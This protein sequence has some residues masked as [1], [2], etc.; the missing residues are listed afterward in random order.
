MT[1]QAAAVALPDAP[2][3]C[4]ELEGDPHNS[5]PGFELGNFTFGALPAGET[6]TVEVRRDHGEDDKDEPG[7]L[8]VYVTVCTDNYPAWM[9]IMGGGERTVV[10]RETAGKPD[11]FG[12]TVQTVNERG[13]VWLPEA[14]F[15]AFSAALKVP[16]LDR[17]TCTNTLK[18]LLEAFGDG[19]RINL[20]RAAAVLLDPDSAEAKAFSRY[21]LRWAKNA[22]ILLQHL[23]RMEVV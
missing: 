11:A 22:V 16:M 4:P 21:N 17:R 14:H 10:V 2:A 13:K 12:V 23:R 3:P 7:P 15:R 8:K 5:S 6:V 18:V 1:T 9:P 20:S 19:S